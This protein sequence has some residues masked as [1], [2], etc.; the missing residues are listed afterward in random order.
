MYLSSRNK[1]GP[2]K[3][4]SVPI[5]AIKDMTEEPKDKNKEQDIATTEENSWRLVRVA[6]QT[7]I[8]SGLEGVVLIAANSRGLVEIGRLLTR[9]N[10]QP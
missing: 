4:R 5:L 7:K 3:F 10:F 2:L 8:L 1:D 6:R 9:D